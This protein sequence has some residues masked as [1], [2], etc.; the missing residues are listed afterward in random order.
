MRHTRRWRVHNYGARRHVPGHLRARP[1]AILVSAE[2]AKDYSIVPG[3]RIKIR[4]PDATGNLKT[5]DFT[6]AGIALEFPTA[7]T[8]AFLVANLGYLVAQTE[9]GTAHV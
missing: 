6:M 3:D 8:D 5:V 1:D 2:T 7:P 4:V 9:V